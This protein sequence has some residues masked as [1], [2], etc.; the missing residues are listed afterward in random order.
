M[1]TVYKVELDNQTHSPQEPAQ[2]FWIAADNGLQVE[3]AL[4]DMQHLVRHVKAMHG[5]VPVATDMDYVLPDEAE[6]LRANV[7]QFQSRR[8]S[9]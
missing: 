4:S 9:A 5:V 3:N 2:P 1:K 7:R 6:N 8:R